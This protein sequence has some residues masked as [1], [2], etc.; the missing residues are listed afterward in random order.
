DQQV[1]LLLD[2]LTVGNDGKMRTTSPPNL[3]FA[4]RFLSDNT[5]ILFVPSNAGAAFMMSPNVVGALNALAD[6]SLRA[7]A[8]GPGVVGLQTFFGGSARGPLFLTVTT[9]LG[10]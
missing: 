10:D 3:G 7:S 6:Q 8:Y 1:W 4:G 9:A 5:S 2:S